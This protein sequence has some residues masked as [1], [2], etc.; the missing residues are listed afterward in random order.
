MEVY[1]FQ[2]CANWEK[3]LERLS[4]AK[5]KFISDFSSAHPKSLMVDPLGF[6]SH[7]TKTILNKFSSKRHSKQFSVMSMFW[8]LERQPERPSVI[9]AWSLFWVMQCLRRKIL[10]HAGT[11][12]SGT[13]W[14]VRQSYWTRSKMY[15]SGTDLYYASIF[16][17][18]LKVNSCVWSTYSL[19]QKKRNFLEVAF[20]LGKS[21]WQ[22]T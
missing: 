12:E 15:T 4:W 18:I 9:Y 16:C 22:W 8:K 2:L 20:L 19:S 6:H 5:H 17:Y 11:Q 14:S 1:S 3:N 21:V 10:W 13:V 7:S